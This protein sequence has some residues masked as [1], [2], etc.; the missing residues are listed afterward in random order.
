MKQFIWGI[1]L[2]LILAF[3]YK[4]NSFSSI[5]TNKSSKDSSLLEPKNKSIDSLYKSWI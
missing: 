2:I 3:F 5:I 4:R 1:L